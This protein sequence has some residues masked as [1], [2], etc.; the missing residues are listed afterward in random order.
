MIDSDAASEARAPTPPRALRVTIAWGN[1]ELRL[2][3]SERVAMIVP[4][5]PTP[6]P[7]EGQSGYWIEVR[8]AAGAL[9]FHR[10]LHNP[11]RRDTEAYSP[12]DRQT[13]T[14]VPLTD[15]QGEFEVLV[16]DAPAASALHLYGPPPGAASD[17]VPAREILRLPYELL[18]RAAAGGSAK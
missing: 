2:A 17:G 6:P 11:I 7:R 16:P 5:A 9:V 12:L 18:R 10:P 15:S 4:G 14:R 1:N 3:G 8:D 13:I